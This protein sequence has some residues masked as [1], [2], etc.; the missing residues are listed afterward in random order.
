ML[1]LTGH[2]HS[3]QSW[4]CSKHFIIWPH[5]TTSTTLWSKIIIIPILQLGKLEPERLNKMPNHTA[6]K[7]WKQNSSPRNLTP[8]LSFNYTANYCLFFD[9]VLTLIHL[10]Y[11][12]HF[13]NL[14]I[15]SLTL[16]SFGCSYNVTVCLF[17]R[18]RERKMDL[19]S[20]GGREGER[21]RREKLLSLITIC[22]KITLCCPLV[23]KLKLMFL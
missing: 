6:N 4:S 2:V 19:R 13:L 5:L 14:F 1:D 16:S 8:N 21:Q 18:E 9:S 15:C 20:K 10:P 22:S 7:W 23:V 11:L 3:K 12:S 17:W